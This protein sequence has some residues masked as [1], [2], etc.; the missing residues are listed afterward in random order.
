MRFLSI[1]ARIGTVGFI[2][3]LLRETMRHPMWEGPLWGGSENP[4]TTFDLAD[5][6]FNEW[7]VATVSYT[8]LTLPT[9]A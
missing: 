2:L 9:K 8:H 4:P 7:A 3:V 5:A 1:L 6:L